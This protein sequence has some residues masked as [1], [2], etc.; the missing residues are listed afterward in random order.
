M[1]AFTHLC[2]KVNISLFDDT[3]TIYPKK[4]GSKHTSLFILPWGI[5]AREM[6]CEYIEVARA[7][8]YHPYELGIIRFVHRNDAD[9]MR[10]H[11][12]SF[13][14][15]SEHYHC[16]FAKTI[17]AIKLKEITSILVKYDI[18]SET[19]RATFLSAYETAT[20]LDTTAA[21]PPS[22][23]AGVTVAD[24]GISLSAYRDTFFPRPKPT[25][26]SSYL[27][28]GGALRDFLRF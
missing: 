12:D 18:L 14:L 26:T 15:E 3:L 13:S 8:E 2:K 7:M 25:G 16:Q 23:R 20:T 10:Y 11:S 28:S 27:A 22:E 24:T 5:M 17:D 21:A 9:H 19:E 1:P 6:E 4:T